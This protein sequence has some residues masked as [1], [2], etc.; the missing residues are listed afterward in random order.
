MYWGV[1]VKFHAFLTL[2]I[3]GNEGSVSRSGHFTPGE[4]TP[5]I[6]WIG[7]WMGPRVSLDAVAKKKNPD[8]C[9]L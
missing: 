2:V 8:P 1:E 5:S 9:K 3:D 6:Q 7:G 4:R